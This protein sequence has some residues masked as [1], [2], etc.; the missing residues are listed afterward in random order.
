MVIIVRINVVQ[1][2]AK[3]W[4]DDPDT[5]PFLQQRAQSD[6]HG[7]VRSAAVE[8]LTKGWYGRLEIFDFL[9]NCVVKEP[10]VRSKN[11][12][13]AQVETDPRQTALI[14][15]VEYFPDHPQTKDLLSDRSQNDP[16]EQV[17]KFA[18]QALES[19]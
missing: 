17:R 13:L 10:F 5:L 6:D 11:K 15:I 1:E 16:D 12:L 14:G 4:K 19:L 7:S 2:L 9:A 3:G 18:Q 8:E